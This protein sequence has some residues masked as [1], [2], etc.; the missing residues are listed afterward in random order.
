MKTG[1][2]SMNSSVGKNNFLNYSEEENQRKKGISLF[3]FTSFND[4]FT[5]GSFQKKSSYNT[6]NLVSSVN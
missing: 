2:S 5:N 1:R 3:K 6:V 4:T